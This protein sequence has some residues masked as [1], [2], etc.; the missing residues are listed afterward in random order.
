M[1]IN[2]DD[3]ESIAGVKK[4]LFNS[5]WLISEQIVRL[6]VGLFVSVWIARHLGPTDFGTLTFLQAFASLFIIIGTLGLNRIV[7]RELVV[8]N[9][10][11]NQ[12]QCLLSTVFLLRLFAA[13]ILYIVSLA[14]GIGFDQAQPAYIAVVTCAVFFTTCETFDLSFQSRVNARPVVLARSVG[15]FISSALKIVL[16]ASGAKLGSFVIMCLADN[17]ISGLAVILAYRGYLGKLPIRSFKVS[18]AY[19]MLGE[20]W[21]EIIAAF[22][23]LLFMRLDQIMLANML[24]TNAV[25]IYSASAKLSEIWYF[26]PVA[27]VSSAFPAVIASR[28]EGANVYWRRLGSLLNFL[29]ALFYAVLMFV[30]IYASDLIPMI[31]G[32]G[33]TKSVAVLH[34]HIWCGLMVCFAQVSGAWLVNEKMIRFNLMRNLTGAMLNFAL[35]CILIPY[36]GALG[37][38]IATM[39]SFVCAYFLFDFFH[40]SLRRM[41]MLKLKSLIFAA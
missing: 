22:S 21:S 9:G 36:Y 32:D 13:C 33:Y 2:I 15:F 35:N 41:G 8:A 27:I 4:I 23:G 37:A 26:L 11:A 17:V 29:V 40:P 14:I 18:L 30:Y 5:G 39:S 12:E 24:D 1:K 38:A 10:D 34:V 16:L 3:K 25:G 7:V 28:E 31:F 6:L 19:A 20:S